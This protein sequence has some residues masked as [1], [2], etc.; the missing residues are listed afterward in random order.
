MDNY[1]TALDFWEKRK[2]Y[3]NYPNTLQRRLIDTNFVVSKSADANS[4]LDIGCGEGSM[5]LSLREFTKIELFYGY[6]ISPSLIKRLVDRWGN[7]PGLKVK[8]VN[9]II[10]RE[11]PM[12]DITLALGSWPYIFDDDHL[13][14][15]LGNIKSNLL[16]VRAPC[17]L[18]KDDEIINK[19]SED[20]GENYASIYRTRD[21]YIS[22]LSKHFSVCE[23][24]RAYPDE[25]ESKYGTK[26]F[27]FVAKKLRVE[28]TKD[29]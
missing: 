5:L 12:T 19:F 28:E 1:K 29:E 6:D 26:H 8:I 17:T 3:P 15:I 7:V 21:N 14:K 24:S 25:I 22:I 4:V 20:L 9:L 13:H 2:R 10:L 18:G 16:I 11:L 27:F 23:V